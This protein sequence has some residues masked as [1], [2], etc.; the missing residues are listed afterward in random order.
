M[1]QIINNLKRIEHGFKHIVEAGDAILADDKVDHF[2]LAVELLADNAYQVRM[3]A[4]HLLGN[5]STDNSKA[6]KLL[7]TKV[8]KD[9]DWRVQEMLAKAFDHY[10][11]AIGYK[12]S[13]PVIE[14]W[15]SNKNP[16]V[17]RAVV[18]G[19]RVWTR[20]PYFKDNPKVAI[21]LVSNNKD[22]ESEYLQ[23]SIGNS[24][25]DIKKTHKELVE[26]EI[27]KWDKYDPKIKFVK[28]LI[29]K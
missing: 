3:L 22:N 19:L 1:K 15:L 18:E 26:R 11:K 9:K 12:E 28:S 4:T 13:L 25:R 24:L 5:L 16:N 23:K 20:R 2:V 10:C 27:S 29:D 6:L 21:A 17:K 8:A 14:K 7:E